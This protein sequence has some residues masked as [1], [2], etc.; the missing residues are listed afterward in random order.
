[1]L[2]QQQQSVP[3]A[4]GCKLHAGYWDGCRLAL[5]AHRR[6]QAETRLKATRAAGG[7]L[8]ASPEILHSCVTSVDGDVV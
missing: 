3:Q 5:A 2:R 4:D 7:R 6:E 8:G 1:M